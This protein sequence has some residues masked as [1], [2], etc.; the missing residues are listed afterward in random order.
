M[1]H[2]D[3]F[4]VQNAKPPRPVDK[5]VGVVAR[6]PEQGKSPIHTA[7]YH[8]IRGHHGSPRSDTVGFGDVPL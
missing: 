5:A 6:R 4:I 1:V 7:V 2:H 3:G 8:Q